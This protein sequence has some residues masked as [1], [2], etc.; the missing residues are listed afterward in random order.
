MKRKSIPV[1]IGNIW[2]GGNHPIVVQSMTNTKTADIKATLRQIKELAGA[3]AEM[4]R[5]TVNNEAAATA[6]PHIIRKLREE[7]YTTPII[8]DFHFNGHILL[9]KYP[10]CAKA[11]DKYRINPGNVGRGTK[12]DANFKAFIDLAIK[13]D[14][15]VRIGVNWGS[16]DPELKDSMMEE[17]A[18]RKRPKNA[19]H[20]LLEAIVQSALQ[21]ARLAESYGMPRNKIVISAKLS[22]VQEFISVNK[23]VAKQCDYAM[24]LGL[25]E[26]GMGEKG[27]VASSAALGILLQ[28]GIGD[29]IRISLTPKPDEKRTKE[30]EICLLLLQTMGFRHFKPLITSCPGCGR[31]KSN[32][33]QKLAEEMNFF[34]KER[35]PVWKGQGL[36]GFDNFSI[37]VMGC[38]VNGPGESKYADIGISFPGDKEKPALPVYIEGKLVKTLRGDFEEIK[39]EFQNMIEAYIQQRCS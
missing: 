11:L 30:V 12:H 23:M 7:D 36:K 35:V 19:K 20:V 25:T 16:L 15:P 2:V 5:L 29:T 17:N 21:S 37:A 13:Y 18:E 10:E 26:A 3:G 24:H 27:I 1:N 4:V 32:R 39:T 14:K 22:E 33:F 9:K 34:I 8:G 38:I 28:Q 31:T 6:V